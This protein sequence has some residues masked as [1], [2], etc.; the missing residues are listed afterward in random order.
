MYEDV[1]QE[2]LMD[3]NTRQNMGITKQTLRK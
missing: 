3:G 1:M 2:A